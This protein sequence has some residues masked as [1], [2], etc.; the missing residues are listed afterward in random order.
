MELIVTRTYTTAEHRP[1]PTW[2]ILAL[3]GQKIAS[4]KALRESAG[5]DHNGGHISLIQC[6]LLV[7]EITK[8]TYAHDIRPA[9]IESIS[10][11]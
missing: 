5:T 6:K 2:L 3:Q 4:I 10:L 11:K 1:L 7:E 9:Q 8:V